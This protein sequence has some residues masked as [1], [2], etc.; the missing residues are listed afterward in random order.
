MANILPQRILP[1]DS[2]TPKRNRV[3]IGERNVFDR[4]VDDLAC[5]DW[6]IL[7]SYHIVNHQTQKEGE[8]DFVIFVPNYGIAVIEVKSHKKIKYEN[9]E[10]FLGDNI[11]PESK[12][13]IKQAKDNMWSM[14]TTL[15]DHK[16]KPS[17]FKKII[18][19]HVCI[20][21]YAKFDYNS[22]EWGDW[23]ICDARKLNKQP[24]S[25]FIVD[26]LK[27][28]AEAERNEGKEINFSYID[29]KSIEKMI[30][31]LRPNLKSLVETTPQRQERINKELNTFTDE[32]ELVFR[33]A[34]DNKNF[35]VT[36]PAGTGK[37]FLATEIANYFAEQNKK[38]LYLCFNRGLKLNLEHKLPDAKFEIKTF[39]GM[40]TE[41][42]KLTPAIG[43]L[44][45]EEYFLDDP[46]YTNF[47][48]EDAYW[49]GAL[50]EKAHEQL[51]KTNEN[52]DVI[53][54]DEFQDLAVEPYMFIIDTLLKGGLASGSWYFFGDF[55]KQNLF[56]RNVSEKEIIKK[57][58]YPSFN[59]ELR[60]N[61]RNTPSSVE[62]I[63]SIS[64]LNPQYDRPIIRS[65]GL[66]EP[67][68]YEYKDDKEQ[69][70]NLNEC[71][72][73][74]KNIGY[75]SNEILILSP[76]AHSLASRADSKHPDISNIEEPK[77]GSEFD[78]G[79]DVYEYN[80]EE[81]TQSKPGPYHTTIQ[82]YKGLEFNV[83]ILTDLDFY[84]Y[85]T[86]PKEELRSLMYVGMTRGLETNILHVSKDVSSSGFIE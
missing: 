56:Q 49:Q 5:E 46:T 1:D 41:K 63:E 30:K 42:S 66:T 32:Q 14:V 3:P 68:V 11:E 73:N 29:R 48:S 62:L 78:L 50:V 33:A 36:G 17:G 53:I 4:L 19:T 38:V 26:A 83:V 13:P 58:G 85:F 86:N 52:Y 71:I 75:K 43:G 25:K 7:H 45:D 55:E 60:K 84:D 24:I 74:M 70:K 22:E 16:S 47:E 76:I 81:E 2:S 12:D 64:N 69:I 31:I 67:T 79:F 54:I 27:K 18:W 57:L 23:Q 37:T 35:T 40:L 82:K 59:I 10:W 8:A 61:C 21:P 80:F 34:K 72:E 15:K 44:V 77:L 6:W 65:E 39:P 28:Q 20:F 9:G 51:L